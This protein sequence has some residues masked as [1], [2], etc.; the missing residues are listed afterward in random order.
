[1]G[2]T[3]SIDALLEEFHANQLLN[4]LDQ[5]N[6]P[7]TQATFRKHGEIRVDYLAKRY[8]SGMLNNIK[9]RFRLSETPCSKVDSARKRKR[10]ESFE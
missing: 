5:G 8:P 3:V 1:M 4:K 7:E 10:Y 6:S 9:F 2:D